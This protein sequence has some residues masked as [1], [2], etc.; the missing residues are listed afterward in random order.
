MSDLFSNELQPDKA[1]EQAT[2]EQA[3]TEQATTEQATAE[4][5]TAEQPTAE[6]AT[7]EQATAEQPTAEQATAEQPTVK[8]RGR[9]RKKIAPEPTEPTEHKDE[10]SLFSDLK[11]FE[12][13][14]YKDV[15]IPD[16][17]SKTNENTPSMKDTLLFLD[18]IISHGLKLFLK[19]EIEPMEELEAEFI[20]SLAP[21]GL[22][23]L[24]PSKSTFFITLG[25]YYISKIF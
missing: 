1:T 23:I 9:P 3:T 13:K 20:G 18:G 8:K 22:E 16:E 11:E 12:Q 15:F 7:A 5:A 6:Q 10:T 2:A 25:A 24:K 4:Q 17:P 19:K 14:E 21:A